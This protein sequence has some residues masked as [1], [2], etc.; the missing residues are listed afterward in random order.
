MCALGKETRRNCQKISGAS[1][2]LRI[3][4]VGGEWV[5]C[6]KQ[7]RTR[8]QRA[9]PQCTPGTPKK[10]VKFVF[11]HK[12]IPLISSPAVERAHDELFYCSRWW[13]FVCFLEKLLHKNENK[14]VFFLENIKSARFMY[15]CASGML[16]FGAESLFAAC[17]CG[18]HNSERLNSHYVITSL[19][20]TEN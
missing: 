18:E 8:L 2:C 17:C 10:W 15:R 9:D 6:P 3:C 20:I 14:K 12:I 1:D 13:W 16:Y 4:R 11:K 19:E 7:L 5:I